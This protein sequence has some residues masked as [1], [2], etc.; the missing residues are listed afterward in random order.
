[1]ETYAAKLAAFDATFLGS[2]AMIILGCA[3]IAYLCYRLA[4]EIDDDSQD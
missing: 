3:W 2:T 1:M 4:H